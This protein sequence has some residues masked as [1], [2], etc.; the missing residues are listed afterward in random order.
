MWSGI[1]ELISCTWNLRGTGDFL[2]ISQGLAGPMRHL[3]WFIFA[4]QCWALWITRNKL[5]IEGRFFDIIDHFLQ[6]FVKK[7]H[8]SN[9]LLKKTTVG[10][11]HALLGNTWY[12]RHSLWRHH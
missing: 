6:C 7:D 3:V 10:W 12:L 11:K 2:A 4:A 9:N 5:T 1:R 8:L